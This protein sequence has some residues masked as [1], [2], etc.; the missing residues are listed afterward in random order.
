M[1]KVIPVP[2]LTTHF[3]HMFLWI[4]LSIA[5]AGVIVANGA[6]NIFAKGTPTFFNGPSNLP[7]NTPRNSINWMIVDHW[8]WLSLYLSTNC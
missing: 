7:N 6:K 4:A 1:T 3:P 5:D 2:A 8:V